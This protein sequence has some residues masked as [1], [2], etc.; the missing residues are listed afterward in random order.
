MLVRAWSR[1]YGL[2]ATISNCCNNYG[3]HQHSEKFIPHSIACIQ[4]GERSKLYGD[5]LNVR[6][7]IHVEDHARAVW[8]I[9]TKGAVGETYLI[10]ANCEH[11]NL[12]VLRTILKAMG[13]SE[14]YVDWVRDRPGHDRRYAID[15]SKLWREFGWTPIH[16][17]FAA[18]VS[19]LCCETPL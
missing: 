14:D 1:T 17:D 12:E 8:S 9:L 6:D 18:E 19:R 7:W 11:S 13:Q 10:G 15:A 5:G 2:K 16:N 4:R 3:P